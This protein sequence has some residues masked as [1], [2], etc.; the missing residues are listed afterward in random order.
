MAVSSDTLR[1]AEETDIKGKAVYVLH[2]WKD[3]LWEMGP[4]KKT[5]PPPPREVQA[6]STVAPEPTDTTETGSGSAAAEATED[7][8]DGETGTPPATKQSV[9]ET[10]AEAAAPGQP[11][12]EQNTAQGLTAEGLR[13]IQRCDQ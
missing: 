7:A 9:K 5:D 12:E 6:Q 2:T 3:A 4:S 1:S 8:A 10:A 13:R 11:T